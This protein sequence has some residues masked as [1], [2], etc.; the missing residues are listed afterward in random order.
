MQRAKA[1]GA[2]FAALIFIVLH[3]PLAVIVISS[4]RIA[5]FHALA[6]V[7][8]GVLCALFAKRAQTVSYV[9]AYIMGCEILW[10]AGNASV[11]WEI[12]KYATVLILFLAILRFRGLPPI[13]KRLLLYFAFLLPSTLLLQTFDRQAIAF[14]LSGPLSLA[15]ATIYFSRISVQRSQLKG[16]LLSAIAP[17]AGL[18]FDAARQLANASSVAFT[19]ASSAAASAGFGPNQVSSLLGLGA[20][21]AFIYVFVEDRGGAIRIVMVAVGLWF[22]AQSAL[23]FSRGGL[24]T[25]GLALIAGGFYLLRSRR[26]RATFLV[27]F[28]I[29]AAVGYFLVLP[30]LSDFTGGLIVQRFSDTSLTGRDLIIR[31]D[32]LAFVE[33]PLLGVGPGQ[34]MAYHSILFRYSNAHTEYSRLVAEHGSSWVA[35]PFDIGL[36]DG[37]AGV[38]K[39]ASIKQSCRDSVHGL[40]VGLYASFG[41]E[42]GR[43]GTSCSVWHRPISFSRK[44]NPKMVARPLRVLMI[45]SEWPTAE[46]PEWVP[47]LVAAGPVPP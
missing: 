5:T 3:L 14:N 34:S 35:G 42:V 28:T 16:I 12:G 33:H 24:W 45:S 10:R 25:A 40:G 47:F 4:Q 30:F 2:Q 17:I 41:H 38:V 29:I 19:D 15:V 46:H 1:L 27:S 8:I 6:T 7:G 26:Q 21:L 11:F 43:A 20:L 39:T 44:G 36:V 23:T 37:T 32:W 9:A 13:D 18:G 22:L 31:T